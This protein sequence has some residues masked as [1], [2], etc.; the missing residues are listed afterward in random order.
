MKYI[1]ISLTLLFA[2][3]CGVSKG[4]LTEKTTLLLTLTE[5]ANPQAIVEDYA[6]ITELKPNSRSQP[7]FTTTVELKASELEKLMGKLEGDT[8]VASVKKADGV[9]G[10]T[11]STNSGFG[12]SSPKPKTN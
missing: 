7:I 4:S 1:L 2:L 9:S 10:N 8:R 11:N 5:K 3:G 12:T 6:E